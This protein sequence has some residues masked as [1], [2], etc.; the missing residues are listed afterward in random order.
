LRPRTP[1]G[2]RFTPRGAPDGDLA[3]YLARQL[4]QATWRYRARV[5]V[6][7]PA[8][9]IAE[10]LPPAVLVEPVD[11]HTCRVEVGSDT[12]DL[13]A[14]YLGMLGAD[15]TVDTEASPELAERVRALSA[16]YAR[17]VRPG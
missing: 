3:G 5:T 14:A 2:P 6:R 4:G 17:S 7:A 9:Q 1:A 15:F 13:L 12:P 16:R 10:R 8:D 11:A